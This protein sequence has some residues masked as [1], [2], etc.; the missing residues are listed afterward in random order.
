MVDDPSGNSFV[1]GEVDGSYDEALKLNYYKRTKQQDEA[2]GIFAAEDSGDSG[3]VYLMIL[4]QTASGHLL[5]LYLIVPACFDVVDILA[6]P[7]IFAI[8]I[9]S[10]K[11]FS[12]LLHE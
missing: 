4:F 8:V 11:G 10:H 5:T 12:I 1:Q 9:P 2:I 6:F 3:Q 7:N